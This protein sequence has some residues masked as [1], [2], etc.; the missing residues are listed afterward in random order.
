M[1][2]NAPLLLSVP[3]IVAVCGDKCVSEILVLGAN[4]RYHPSLAS[5]PSVVFMICVGRVRVFAFVE[6]C[7]PSW[8]ARSSTIPDIF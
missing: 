7:A 5:T 8:I 3:Q 2:P 4:A 6:R 1:Y